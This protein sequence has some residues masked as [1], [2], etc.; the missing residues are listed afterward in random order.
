MLLVHGDV[1]KK[2]GC[3]KDRE[4]DPRILDEL[5][6]E[7]DDAPRSGFRGKAVQGEAPDLRGRA[8]KSTNT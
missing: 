7:N 1:Y 5:F 3:K 8:R 4:N 6:S 2:K